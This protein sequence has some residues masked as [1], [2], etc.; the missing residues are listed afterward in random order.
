MQ[1]RPKKELKYFIEMI[2]V[3]AIFWVF[4]IHTGYD[5]YAHFTRVTPGSREYWTYMAITIFSKAAVPLFLTITG[6]V[7]L[8]KE[9]ESLGRIWRVRIPRILFCLVLYSAFYYALGVY[10]GDKPASV[11]E[12]LTGLYRGKVTV[13]M[14]YLYAY[15]M[16][17]ILLPFTRTLVQNLKH[18]YFYYFMFLAVIF[19]PI[20]SMTEFLLSSGEVAIQYNWTLSCIR[21]NYV[22]YPIIGYFLEQRMSDKERR[23][24][25]PLFFL[26]SVALLGMACFATDM[27]VILRNTQ[28][29]KQLENFFDFPSFV[30]APF[31]FLL[32]K[33]ISTHRFPNFLKKFFLAIGPCTMGVY[34]T[35]IFFMRNTPM[36]EIP[37]LLLA[38]GFNHVQTSLLF[39]AITLV[40]LY[41]I[42]W[43]IRKVPVLRYLVGG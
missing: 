37:G 7:L 42:I 4:F 13:H 3:Y 20:I 29:V 12:F 6:A 9:D 19:G 16:L 2:R 18:H 32:F 11:S 24:L 34:L 22:Y 39:S 30:Q 5:G 40:L 35:H 33:E 28:D 17:L 21:V 23:I 41:P 31:I 1:T 10:T 43:V 25:L 27:L 26:M 15:V 36:R 8:H 14:G 38:H